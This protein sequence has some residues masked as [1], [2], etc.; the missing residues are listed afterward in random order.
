M[1]PKAKKMIIG[2]SRTSSMANAFGDSTGRQKRITKRFGPKK[3]IAN[4]GISGKVPLS[5]RPFISEAVA[6]NAKKGIP[7]ELIFENSTRLARSLAVQE[8]A[9]QWATDNQVTLVNASMPDLWVKKTPENTLMSQML[10]SF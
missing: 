4:V 10:G 3:F 2:V 5:L 1:A 8:E 6:E 9:I 7:T